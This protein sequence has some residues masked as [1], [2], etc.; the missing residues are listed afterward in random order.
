[1]RLTADEREIARASGIS[2]TE[3]ARHKISMM[4]KQR[5]GEIQH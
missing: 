3:Y 1:V 5:A 2:E 4:K